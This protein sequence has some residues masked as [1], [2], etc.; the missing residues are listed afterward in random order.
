[1]KY[2][3]LITTVMLCASMLLSC[4]RELEPWRNGSKGGG[5]EPIVFRALS[6]SLDYEIS[7]RSA[8]EATVTD[9]CSEGFGVFV[10]NTGG[11]TF[12]G[13]AQQTM[14]AGN[15]HLTS[16]D[17]GASWDYTGTPVMWN[18]ASSEKYSFFAYFPYSE[19]MSSPLLD[20]GWDEYDG[21]MMVSDCRD[22]LASK[23][24]FNQTSRNGVSL[25]FEHIFSK[26][27]PEIKL[28][29]SSP[30][31]AY[32]L[33]MMALGN[34]VQYP[35][36]DLTSGQ[37]DRSSSESVWMYA[38]EEDFSKAYISS[39][40]E[41]LD[42]TSFLICPHSYESSSEEIIA[43]FVFNVYANGAFSKQVVKSISFK[44]NFLMNTHYKLSILFTPEEDDITLS[45]IVKDYYKEN[46]FSPILSHLG[47]ANCYV[48]PTSGSY[49]FDARYKGN[50]TTETVGTIS[51]VDVLWESYG[52]SEAL[53]PGSLVSN[54]RYSDGYIHFRASDRKGN[55]VVAAKD[56]G[57]N[58]LWSWHLWL[59]DE[60]EDQKYRNNAGVAM[61][62]NLG[63]TSADA[64]DGSETFGLFYQWGRKDPFLGADGYSSSTRMAH[65]GAD[66][67]S[68]VM[69]DATTGTIEY[70]N[71]NP[72]SFVANT[73]GYDW[74]QESDKYLW[75]SRI[76]EKSIYDPC[77]PGYRIP[78]IDLW[79]DV[80][81]S[82]SQYPTY[83]YGY[84]FGRYSSASFTTSTSSW[85]PSTGIL[86]TDGS[87]YGVG[88]ASYLC[89]MDI[90]DPD[91]SISFTYGEG[92]ISDSSAPNV[93][94][95]SVRCAR[96]SDVHNLSLEGA[97]NCYIVPEAGEYR[98]TA[99]KGN[100][101]NLM[102]IELAVVA[103][104]SFGTDESI[105]AGDLIRN[106]EF[107][108]STITFTAS[109]RKGNA[110]IA[111][112][113]DEGQIWSWHIWL[114]DYPEDQIYNNG[115][116]IAMDRNLGATSA[117][118]EDLV[119]TYGLLYQWGRKDPFLGVGTP[120]GTDAAAAA[121]LPGLEFKDVDVEDD[122]SFGTVEFATQNPTTYIYDNFGWLN[123]KDT[124]LWGEKK[125]M[126]APCP[127][128]YKVPSGGTGGFWATAAGTDSD[129][130]E[131][132]GLDETYY[133]YELAGSDVGHFSSSSHSCWYPAVGMYVNGHGYAG[134]GAFMWSSSAVEDDGYGYILGVGGDE[135]T[136]VHSISTVFAAGVRCVKE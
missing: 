126:Y 133:G 28:T 134:Y 25:E 87:L 82:F 30:G 23:P 54:V 92:L 74:L 19:T 70:A 111:A 48:V 121:T 24:V 76:G 49:K 44:K 128:G 71:K 72:M 118:K 73:D 18:T 81:F 20:F 15:A 129:V 109:G 6:S 3:S 135:L 14:T 62:R 117:R 112:V 79:K 4:Q 27:S 43:S 13:E 93:I 106:L 83:S 113:N 42:V 37:Y 39:T 35:S 90:A 97:A 80:G 68:P 5:I 9:L 31:Y 120:D 53:S 91:M 124:S 2:N 32:G 122:S 96:E 119:K 60:P 65:A 78:S 29:K 127:A 98:F 77:P 45:A 63:A 107:S 136:L 94:G 125:T 56:S 103:W 110:L 38:V 1:M 108:G 61:D 16:S 51:S 104:E 67:P 52:T 116:G 57:G 41:S 55:A 59:T 131:I 22:I 100:S 40:S 64:S 10:Y 130:C 50:S 132:D 69:T 46:P 7:T 101:G 26:I 85:Y 89:C 115:A 99:T 36:Y 105:S 88:V 114:T 84:D 12:S 33:E 11:D 123:E 75:N 8:L 102:D 21:E 66:W 34:I 86:Y 58:I 95:A 17:G 47:T